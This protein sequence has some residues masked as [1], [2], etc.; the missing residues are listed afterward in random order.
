MADPRPPRSGAAPP[1]EA[2][3]WLESLLD[4][5]LSAEGRRAMAREVAEFDR[6]RTPAGFD[7]ERVRRALRFH[8]EV[9]EPLRARLRHWL[10]GLLAH[11][12]ARGF[13]L[14]DLN[15]EVH[16]Y[17][18]PA[19]QAAT[20]APL[21]EGLR[22]PASSCAFNPHFRLHT[23]SLVLPPR[24]R[25]AE[26]LLTVLRAL[27]A[28]LV[29]DV[30]LHEYIFTREAYR[31]ELERSAARPTVG[32][33]EQ[34]AVLAHLP[35]TPP[36]LAAALEAHGK[37]MGLSYRRAP[38]P[39]R[40]A[41]FAD[42]E[43]TAAEGRLPPEQA[44]LVERLFGDFQAGLERDL[45]GGVAAM[46]AAVE[47]VNRQV[48]FLPPVEGPHYAQLKARNPLHFLRAAKLRLD[49]LSELLGTVLEDFAVLEGS[50]DLAAPL[51][52]ERL[53]AQMAE[54]SAQ[55]LARAYLVPDVQLSE[56]LQARRDAFP[57]EVHTLLGQLPPAPDPGRAYA[58]LRRRLEN[59]IHQRLYAALLYMQAW[60]RARGRGQDEAFRATPR[61]RQLGGAMGNFRLRKPL[62]DGLGARLGV[63]L[64][65]AER[66]DA[67][68]AGRARLPL[69]A[70]ARAWSQLAPHDL[71][72]GYFAGVPEL[73]GFDPGR[74]RE[75][76]AARWRRQIAAGPGPHHLAYLWSRLGE[77]ADDALAV[78]AELLPEPSGTFRF[79][80][81]QALQPPA[82]ESD[83]AA[84]PARLEEL[85]RLVLRAR[86]AS[87][88]N[89]IV[90]GAEATG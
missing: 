71:I 24:V 23:V 65:T 21:P 43:R 55:G 37:A 73:P 1:Q 18:P 52:E 12:A 85:A 34:I 76:V 70:L 11:A 3:R 14:G 30:F 17:D 72:A 87:R 82:G 31:E 44:A 41:F 5:R 47:E 64:D 66:A 57:L 75:A 27:L 16:L 13:S 80:V 40:R 78:L 20:G 62:L 2:G 53:A 63:V 90:V 7:A 49:S 9:P 48:N 68:L 83:P 33:A 45:T 46:V 50:G 38:Q 89:A 86:E 8:G 84:R 32:Q 29:G 42:L 69:D 81:H 60:L 36:A 4:E 26:T 54:L 6:T 28:R 74:Y 58:A 88:A 22:L 25:T 77:G 10:P 67:A 51:V 15:V 35:E 61:F 59:N 56:E 19:Y 79:A 39:V